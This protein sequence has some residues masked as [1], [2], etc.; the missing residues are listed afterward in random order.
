MAKVLV[1]DDQ[2]DIRRSLVDI[3]FY[4]GYDVIE[5]ADGKAAIQQALDQGPD[6]ILLDVMMPVMD[7]LEALKGLRGILGYSGDTS[8]PVDGGGSLEG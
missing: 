4:G 1:V 7:G 5:A 2:R 6:I 8:N 3:L